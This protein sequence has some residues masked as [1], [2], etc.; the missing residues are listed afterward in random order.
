M[1]R[2]LRVATARVLRLVGYLPVV[3]DIDSWLGCI[4][5]PDAAKAEAQRIGYA[6]LSIMRDDIHDW[7]VG[8]WLLGRRPA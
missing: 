3:G 2:Y 1:P 8:Y 4:V 5:S 6:D 7:D